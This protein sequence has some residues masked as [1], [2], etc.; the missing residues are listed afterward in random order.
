MSFK[1]K[2]II[3]YFLGTLF[4]I[5]LDQW[6]KYIA[7][8]NLSEAAITGE[9][10]FINFFSNPPAVTGEGI[11]LIDNIIEW[12]LVY[13]QGMAWG[14]FAGNQ[15]V[16]IS[17]A[18]IAIAV[19]TFLY[20]RSG[21]VKGSWLIRLPLIL[22]VGGGFGNLVDRIFRG[23]LFKGVVVDMIYVKCI[24]FP[25]F[26]VADSCIT[27]GCVLLMLSLWLV[28]DEHFGFQEDKGKIEE[29]IITKEEET[30]SENN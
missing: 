20:F 23:E 9:K 18:V 12:H 3:A 29:N 15:V 5:I 22:M 8:L 25:V 30:D 4:L 11:P 28:K 14:M 6:T 17:V 26:N 24:D 21:Q 10:G 16:L 2:K 19:F 27:V 13:N 1:T 7:L